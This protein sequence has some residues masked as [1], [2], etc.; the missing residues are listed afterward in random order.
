MEK[1]LQEIDTLRKFIEDGDILKFW[2]SGEDLAMA[3]VR[4]QEIKSQLQEKLEQLNAEVE[5][6]KTRFR[7][8]CHAYFQESLANNKPISAVQ[9]DGLI[10]VPRYNRDVPYSI[11][12]IHS[13]FQENGLEPPPIKMQ[14]ETKLMSSPQKKVYK[15]LERV[16]GVS[17]VVRSVASSEDDE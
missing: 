5:N 16:T 14:I 10:A 8:E 15:G 7:Q 9:K 11:P 2:L 6:E 12:E 1:L 17:V 3:K 13:I 4:Y